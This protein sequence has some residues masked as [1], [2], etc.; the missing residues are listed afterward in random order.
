MT[1]HLHLHGFML[2]SEFSSPDIKRTGALFFFLKASASLR[3]GF[4]LIRPLGRQQHTENHVLK[5]PI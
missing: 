4:H 2:L 5:S 3:L 1:K